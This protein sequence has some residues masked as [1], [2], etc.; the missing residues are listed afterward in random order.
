MAKAKKKAKKVKKV[1]R[2]RKA[3]RVAKKPKKVSWL[4]KGYPVLS[5]VT[6]TRRLRAGDRLVHESARR[7]AAA[8]PRHARAER[9]RTVS[10]GSATRF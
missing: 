1:S 8:P 7:Q 4:A 9:S 5:S 6:C 10:S 3:T 2:A